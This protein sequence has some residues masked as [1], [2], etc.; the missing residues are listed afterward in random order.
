[1]AITAVAYAVTNTVTYTSKVTYKGTPTS[2]KPANVAYQGIL[3][4]D[5]DPTGQQPDTAPITSVY[6]AKAIKNNA[7]YFPFCNATEIDGQPS[8]PAK[9]SKA[10]VGTGSAS[11]LA[12]TPGN[13]ST[14]SIRENLSV[15]AVNGPKG[16]SI[17]LVLNSTPD[18]PVQIQNRVVPGTVV[19]SSGAFAFLVRF[20]VPADLQE[21]LGLRIALTDFNVKISGTPR[22]VKVGKVF[23]KIAYLQ[24]ISC[25]GSLPVKSIVQFKDSANGDVI[26]P[27]TS[28]SSAKC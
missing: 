9:C 27:V 22:K 4:I 21:Q 19:K 1:M 7:K 23:K 16:K 28:T 6:F 15:T 20:A 10:K 14:Q 13:P 24:L 12:G 11:A 2:T 25:K 3:H 5:T 17:Y 18:A 26:K 8:M